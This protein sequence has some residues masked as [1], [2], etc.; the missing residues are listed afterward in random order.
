MAIQDRREN[1]WAIVFAVGKGA[2]LSTLTR[3][4]SNELMKRFPQPRSAASAVLAARGC[5]ATCPASS[6]RMSQLWVAE[7]CMNP[8]ERRGRPMVA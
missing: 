4:P 5:A 7:R 1:L 6:G 2:R 8:P 3:V